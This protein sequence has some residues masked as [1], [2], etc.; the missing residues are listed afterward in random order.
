MTIRST[1]IFSLPP[2][3]FRPALTEA[4]LIRP[5]SDSCAQDLTRHARRMEASRVTRAVP[6]PPELDRFRI[7]V[8]RALGLSARLRPMAQKA[9]NSGVLYLL[10]HKPVDRKEHGALSGPVSQCRLALNWGLID[11]WCK[12]RPGGRSR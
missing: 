1:D 3:L 12:G 10:A 4:K 5:S 8:G 11:S 9:D 2:I 7:C 6:N